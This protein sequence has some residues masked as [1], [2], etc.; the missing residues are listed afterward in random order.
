LSRGW[1]LPAEN[2]AWFLLTVSGSFAL[3]YEQVKFREENAL[4]SANEQALR[5][6]PENEEEAAG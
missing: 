3:E 1:H 5:M 2:L 6:R 4:C